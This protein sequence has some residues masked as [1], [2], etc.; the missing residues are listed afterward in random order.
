MWNINVAIDHLRS[1]SNAT[2]IGLCAQ[3]TRNA[4]EAGGLTLVRKV[5]AKDYGE[6]LLA[7]GFVPVRLGL[8]LQLPVFLNFPSRDAFSSTMNPF[9]SGDVAVFQ[10]TPASEHGHMQMYDGNDWISDFIQT[11]FSPGPSFNAAKVQIYRH[12]QFL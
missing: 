9:Q 7:A 10:A 5:S 1:S 4:I 3:F 6:S 8:P 11:Q 2:S 12:R